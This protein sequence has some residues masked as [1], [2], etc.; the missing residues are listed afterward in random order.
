MSFTDNTPQQTFDQYRT[1]VVVNNADNAIRRLEAKFGELPPVE[2]QK[3]AV[4]AHGAGMFVLYRHPDVPGVV[5]EQVA[6]I[7]GDTLSSVYQDHSAV[8]D[9]NALVRTRRELISAISKQVGLA[10]ENIWV[11][12]DTRGRSLSLF[13]LGTGQL[14]D[15]LSEVLTPSG[16]GIEL[17]NTIA[18]APGVH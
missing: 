4:T 6:G 17:A 16:K 13:E 14:I 12:D 10:I 15:L 1:L 11:Q 5:A 18:G 8:A 3:H 2:R 7:G 9:V